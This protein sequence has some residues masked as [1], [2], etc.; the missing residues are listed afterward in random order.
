M[1]TANLRIRLVLIGGKEDLY[2]LTFAVPQFSDH[3]P[4]CRIIATILKMFA[5]LL[6]PVIRNK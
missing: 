2:L 3:F 4:L 1:D 6:L 5:L